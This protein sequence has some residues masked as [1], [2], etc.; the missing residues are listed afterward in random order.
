MVA[1]EV[2]CKWEGKIK[3][4]ETSAPN[5][6]NNK[7][8]KPN[9]IK[10]KKNQRKVKEIKKI[11]KPVNCE[12]TNEARYAVFRSKKK[13]V[14][15]FS[16]LGPLFQMQ[17]GLLC[18]DTKTKLEAIPEKEGYEGTETQEV[19]T[20]RKTDTNQKEPFLLDQGHVLCF[21]LTLFI[22]QMYAALSTFLRTW[23]K[24]KLPIQNF[25]FKIS[26]AN[27]TIFLFIF[28]LKICTVTVEAKERGEKVRKIEGGKKMR[29]QIIKWIQFW[30]LLLFLFLD[31]AQGQVQTTS[32]GTKKSK[33]DFFSNSTVVIGVIAG[34]VVVILIVFCVLMAIIMRR[35]RS[36]SVILTALHDQSNYG[37]SSLPLNTNSGM[38][39]AENFNKPMD[40]N[41]I[42]PVALARPSS[43]NELAKRDT[44]T[45]SEKKAFEKVEENSL[46]KKKNDLHALTN[47]LPTNGHVN[48]NDNG[49][50]NGNGTVNDNAAGNSNDNDNDDND[51]MLQTVEIGL[52]LTDEH[53]RSLSR[54]KYKHEA[55]SSL[56]GDEDLDYFAE[57][58]DHDKRNTVA[59]N[60]KAVVSEEESTS[61]KHS[62]SGS[63]HSQ[64]GHND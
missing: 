7:Y 43:N 22:Q 17:M 20:N 16:V 3:N 30:L 32:P 62:V 50:N 49:S 63:E 42:V 12:D 54:K 52:K 24:S 23:S 4:K 37:R 28:S 60:P 64:S 39:Q 26:N 48:G 6:I 45:T 53:R 44:H 47:D 35:I 57:D 15:Y 13:T 40:F 59:N 55:H 2:S 58:D 31:E 41:T 34:G 25:F 46:S 36:R 38:I 51:Y 8:L 10:K 21:A 56:F 9:K 61:R 27:P 18:V 14:R 33:T 1:T 11:S 5:Q 29:L 19:D